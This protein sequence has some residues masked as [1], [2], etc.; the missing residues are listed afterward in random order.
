MDDFS[1]FYEKKAGE[2]KK[3]KKFEDALNYTDKA[4]EIKEEQK[5]PNFWYKRGIRFL[6]FGEYE[7]ALECFEKDLALREKTF[8]AFFVKGKVLIQLKKYSESIEAFNKAAEE[9]NKQYLQSSKKA[10]HMKNAKK[11]EKALLYGDMALEEK[12]L[13]DVFWHYKGIAF[14]KLKKYD[15]ADSCF[16]S[17]LEIKQDN[18]ECLYDLAKCKLL[19]GN[20]EK[21]LEILE[22][23]CRIDSRVKEKL[24]VDND[25]S[26]LSENKQF[27]IILG[28]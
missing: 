4:D 2:L 9:R 25:F 6:E 15:E 17:A 23:T 11:F 20:Q 5:A 27:R 19:A 18:S 3:A 22:N 16:T 28:L 14:L 21:C 26:V 7:K 10:E 24:K 8:D 12:P 1:S 13:D